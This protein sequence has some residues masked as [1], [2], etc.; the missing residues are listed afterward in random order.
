MPF[1]MNGTEEEEKMMKMKLPE[2]IYKIIKNE[3]YETDDIGMSLASVQIYK[4][5][6]LKVQEYNEESENEYRVMQYLY[7]KLPVPKVYAYEIS[8]NKSYLLMS[9]C[10]GQMACADEYMGSPEML[11][12]LLASGL[13][14][15]W[16]IKISEDIPRQDLSQKLAQAEYNVTHGLVDLD[17][18]EP[19]TFGE[20]GFRNPLELLQWLYQNRPKEELALSHGDYCLPNI[21]G[22][23]GQVSGYI[24]LGKTGI[25]DKWCDIAICYRSLSHNYGG[26]YNKKTHVKYDD[27][28]LFRELGIE[29]DWEKIRY[30]ILLDE[31]F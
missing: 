21:F 13:K 3:S 4:D 23:Q 31:L 24:D 2:K 28:L 26:K 18:I 1:G 15:L 14:K 11:C 22:I 25:A 29:P 10:A 7:E 8:D 30:Y 27:A 9:K 17:N 16:S 12:K 20:N 6:V 5:K 19:D